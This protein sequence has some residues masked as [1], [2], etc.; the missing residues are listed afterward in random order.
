MEG[1]SDAT[2][3]CPGALSNLTQTL[4]CLSPPKGVWEGGLGHGLYCWKENSD[5]GWI[6]GVHRVSEH[7]R[8]EVVCGSC[9]WS[10]PGSKACGWV[11]L[12]G[13]PRNVGF[14]PVRD[15][16]LSVP[17]VRATHELHL[18]SLTLTYHVASAH[19]AI[20]ESTLAPS[21]PPPNL[22]R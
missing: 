7:R 20:G 18:W 4:G 16:L 2:A 9:P 3:P 5:A 11:L 13:S 6:V 12:A 1:E 15:T 19:L 14:E 21:P 8:G 22:E 10:E 17:G